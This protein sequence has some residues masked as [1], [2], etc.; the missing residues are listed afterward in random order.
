MAD[1]VVLDLRE[2]AARLKGCTLP[3]VDRVVGI[4]SGGVVPAA[5]AA[6][7]LSAP[8]SVITINYRAPDNTPRYLR[9]A[10][11]GPIEPPVPGERILLVDDV[12]VSGA[13]LDAARALLPG[14][15]VTTLVMKG[16][17]DIVLFPEVVECVAWPWER[18][19]G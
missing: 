7:E 19:E 6:Y 3:E 17:A 14:A 9:P 8:L 11:L 13:T 10:I 1:K 15:I 12:S 4:G 18:R 2:I 16:Q 5:L